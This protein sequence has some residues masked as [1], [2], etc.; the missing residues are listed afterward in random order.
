MLVDMFYEIILKSILSRVVIIENDISQKEWYDASLV[1]NNDKND[2]HY[3]INSMGN[4]DLR[5]LSGY[6]YINV[7]ES[8]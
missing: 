3:T 6:I 5:M 4:N 8:R 7:N 1:K 2:L